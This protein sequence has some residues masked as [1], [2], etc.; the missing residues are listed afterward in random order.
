MRPFRAV[1]YYGAYPGLKPRAESFN[2]FGIP[3]RQSPQA[4]F[5]PEKLFE[6][7]LAGAHFS[8]LKLHPHRAGLNSPVS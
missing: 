4:A 8:Y 1:R 2:P 5:F 3:H 7:L 6:I